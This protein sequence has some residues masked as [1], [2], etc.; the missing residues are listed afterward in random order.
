[1][2]FWFK[3][4]DNTVFSFCK[5]NSNLTGATYSTSLKNYN[6]FQTTFIPNLTLQSV[7]FGFSAL[8]DL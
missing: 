3:I 6:I 8:S 2:L 7:I 4:A 5:Q 1:M